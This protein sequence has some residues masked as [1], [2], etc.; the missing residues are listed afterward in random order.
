MT[1][2]NKIPNISKTLQ[3]IRDTDFISITEVKAFDAL[4]D[5]IIS[6]LSV[7]SNDNSSITDVSEALNIAQEIK[8]IEFNMA[9]AINSDGTLNISTTPDPTTGETGGPVYGTYSMDTMITKLDELYLKFTKLVGEHQ[10]EWKIDLDNYYQNVYS[11]FK[12]TITSIFSNS[13]NAQVIE[14]KVNTK[15][16][17]TKRDAVSLKPNQIMRLNPDTVSYHRHIN[18]ITNEAN[19]DYIVCEITELETNSLVLHLNFLNGTNYFRFNFI[20][21]NGEAF[22]TKEESFKLDNN[23]Y[24]IK[25]WKRVYNNQN[26]YCI[27]L[28]SDKGDNTVKYSF[29]FE[30]L[31]IGKYDFSTTGFEI[32]DH[33][34]YYTYTLV[35]K[36]TVTVPEYNV[37]YYY[38]DKV[39]IDDGS[40]STEFNWKYVTNL[41]NWDSKEYYIRKYNFEK[42]SEIN[43]DSNTDNGTVNVDNATIDGKDV[44]SEKNPTVIN[45]KY[46]TKDVYYTNVNV[47]SKDLFKNKGSI[48][49]FL[50]NNDL[51]TLDNGVKFTKN[52]TH[53][54]IEHDKPSNIN[55]QLAL[56]IGS[57]IIHITPLKPGQYKNISYYKDT[58]DIFNDYEYVTPDKSIINSTDDLYDLGKFFFDHKASSTYSFINSDL[59]T[60]VINS[61]DDIVSS[62]DIYTTNNGKILVLP[63]YVDIPN[64]SDGNIITDISAFV[65]NENNEF[66]TLTN[67]K[68]V[69]IAYKLLSTDQFNDDHEQHLIMNSSYYKLFDIDSN[70]KNFILNYDKISNL[71]IPDSNINDAFYNI[72]YINKI[73]E[74][75]LSEDDEHLIKIDVSVDDNEYTHSIFYN[76]SDNI[77]SIPENIGRK[78]YYSGSEITDKVFVSAANFSMSSPINLTIANDSDGKLWYSRDGLSWKLDTRIDY[79]TF[80][81]KEIYCDTEGQFF[82]LT[83][84]NKLVTSQNGYEWEVVDT[85]VIGEETIKKVFI[86]AINRYFIFTDKYAYASEDGFTWVKITAIPTGEY[87]DIAW[88]TRK[89][90]IIGSTGAYHTNDSKDF[91]SVISGFTNVCTGDFCNV[92]TY[93][94]DVFVISGKS[95]VRYSNANY[96]DTTNVPTFATPETVPG[97]E[98][99]DHKLIN[100]RMMFNI[101]STAYPAQWGGFIDENNNIC[102]GAVD[103]L[104]GK[105]RLTGIAYS[106]SLKIYVAVSESSGLWYSYDSRYWVQSDSLTTS[107]QTIGYGKNAVL[108]DSDLALFVAFT[109][110]GVYY[111]TDAKTWTAGTGPTVAIASSPVKF[112][113]YWYI[114]TSDGCWYSSDGKTWTKSDITSSTI[115]NYL[116]T[117]GT[118]L[119]FAGNKSLYYVDT[120]ATAIT[121]INTPGENNYDCLVYSDG[122]FY[123][124]ATSSNILYTSTNGKTWST[125]YTFTNGYTIQRVAVNGNTIVVASNDTTKVPMYS[126]DGGKSFANCTGPAVINDVFYS[127]ENNKFYFCCGAAGSNIYYSDDG[128]TI[129]PLIEDGMGSIDLS[130]SKAVSSKTEDATTY[131]IIGYNFIWKDES[132]YRSRNGLWWQKV[133]FT[134]KI[135][136]I[137]YIGE[138]GNKDVILT[139]ENGG[140]YK[141]ILNE[142]TENGTYT[143]YGEAFEATSYTSGNYGNVI[144]SCVS[145]VNNYAYLILNK[146]T[147]C[148][149]L[150]MNYKKNSIISV[151]K[152]EPNLVSYVGNCGDSLVAADQTEYLQW[153]FLDNIYSPNVSVGNRTINFIKSVSYSNNIYNILGLDNSVVFTTLKNNDYRTISNLSL[154][155]VKICKNTLNNDAIIYGFKTTGGIVT[156]GPESDI[157]TQVFRDLDNYIIRNMF[158]KDDNSVIFLASE[159]SNP[160]NYIFFKSEDYNTVTTIDSFT[161]SV[162]F[163]D[164]VD[165]KIILL[166]YSLNKDEPDYTKQIFFNNA[167]SKIVNNNLV[168]TLNI[169]NFNSI[170]KYNNEYYVLNTVSSTD[171]ELKINFGKISISDNGIITLNTSKEGIKTYDNSDVYWTSFVFKD[172]LYFTCYNKKDNNENG[173]YKVKIDGTGWELIKDESTSLGTYIKDNINGPV[174]VQR[175]LDESTEHYDDSNDNSAT[176]KTDNIN[177][178]SERIYFD[179]KTAGISLGAYWSTDGKFNLTTNQVTAVKSKIGNNINIAI[180]L[181]SDTKIAIYDKLWDSLKIL[182]FKYIADKTDANVPYYK[183]VASSSSVITAIYSGTKESENYIYFTVYDKF[184]NVTHDSYGNFSVS[185]AEKASRRLFKVSVNDIKSSINSGNIDLIECTWLSYITNPEEEVNV[186]LAMNSESIE[187]SDNIIMNAPLNYQYLISCTGLKYNNI[188]SIAY[189]DLVNSSL[190]IVTKVLWNTELRKKLNIIDAFNY[191]TRNTVT[192]QFDY[193]NTDSLDSNGLAKGEM[194]ISLKADGTIVQTTNAVTTGKLYQIGDSGLS[195]NQ[196]G[197][198]TKKSS[199]LDNTIKDYRLN[200]GSKVYIE[201][202]SNTSKAI[203][204]SN[205]AALILDQKSTSINN[206]GFIYFD[207]DSSVELDKFSD[208]T[209]NYYNDA[210]NTSFGLFRWFNYSINSYRPKEYQTSSDAYNT[211][212]V[213]LVPKN[214]G[215]TIII[216]LGRNSYVNKI[217]ETYVGIFINIRSYERYGGEDIAKYVTYLMTNIPEDS[218]D[219]INITDLHYF[220]TVQ[221]DNDP[222]ID[223]ADTNNG[224]FA[225]TFDAVRTVIYRW[226]GDDFYRVRVDLNYNTGIKRVFDTSIGTYFIGNKTNWGLFQYN[227]NTDTID[228]TRYKVYLSP[229]FNYDHIKTIETDKG[230][231]ICGN[232]TDSST[233][234]I[235]YELK[236]GN[237]LDL[238]AVG[239][240]G[241]PVE[242]NIVDKNYTN[243]SKVANLL[244]EEYG[245]PIDTPI[246]TVGNI[247]L[248]GQIVP[249]KGLKVVSKAGIGNDEP[250]SVEFYIDEDARFNP[251]SFADIEGSLKNGNIIKY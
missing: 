214:G 90:I 44:T 120:P 141:S 132:F 215:K 10:T 37:D 179:T 35:D 62:V 189:F 209:R 161:G 198:I 199:I 191:D 185:V 236:T 208:G 81:F 80:N 223:M 129:T 105:G 1:Y 53:V 159:V 33:K 101:R 104:K 61:V 174:V 225:I 24:T 226:N 13:I 84:D 64:D 49:K 205:N 142:Y 54:F 200:D 25:L 113:N 38:K 127:E 31:L 97:F 102:F 51:Y 190:L 216:N 148:S 68:L 165:N 131:D 20:I 150:Y 72:P 162:Q 78:E 220:K 233:E 128:I 119:V 183:N 63:Q 213:Y 133:T 6:K 242:L 21:D 146:D 99:I 22:I 140:I 176:W 187:K 79:D 48:N 192:C 138:V 224:I 112:G 182:G 241:L 232:K 158:I 55:G 14:E 243:L 125:L 45:N 156:I 34:Q 202:T 251:K 98:F 137:S 114:G 123:A 167:T 59:I 153:D 155:D 221:T 163:C 75:K 118:T 207:S 4:I 18:I 43:I 152:Y 117:N 111:S 238:G 172:N 66:V 46:Y 195:L 88:N 103:A 170:T 178:L 11:D 246:K 151:N 166:A 91:N 181:F 210:L 77:I 108:W 122:K 211:G 135:N 169:L 60:Y 115:V 217:Y 65:L 147:N 3:S 244:V 67:S 173:L 124:T 9:D 203:E 23:N 30:G 29:E 74:I 86:V 240:V 177:Y 194:N 76:D 154:S 160:S 95:G 26:I 222:I 69:P 96:G 204:I 218:E 42:I 92:T 235:I 47:E 239:Q 8:K 212:W 229:L 219:V 168:D 39:P 143:T 139:L 2:N 247:I 144:S 109:G 71:F 107:T 89:Y 136:D 5:D 130:D 197:T 249:I 116:A 157:V 180:G 193:G 93:E 87:R 171:D 70:N 57:K 19:K 201:S 36:N 110:G 27:T 234:R 126:I 121:K 164:L 94:D 188:D 206:A 83:N 149:P 56:G 16:D 7:I 41:R 227:A 40:E 32:S 145:D 58:S 73:N 245:L 15:Y 12:A 106:P 85:S 230:I 52:N 248:N 228:E 100:N 17:Y 134:N 196:I 82:G 175:N 50:K 231:F 186:T 28:A 237:S 250:E 184:D